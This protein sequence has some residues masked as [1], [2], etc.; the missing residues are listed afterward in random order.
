M[1]HFIAAVKLAKI[2]IY[3]YV[4]VFVFTCIFFL[5]SGNRK[6]VCECRKK[7][8]NMNRFVQAPCAH[9]FQRSDIWDEKDKFPQIKQ[10]F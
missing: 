3:L 10:T 5:D 9:W 8:R 1:L 7:E 6:S 2:I 4:F